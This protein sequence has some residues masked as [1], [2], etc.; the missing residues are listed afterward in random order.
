ME[1][2]L[3]TG[4]SG[5]LGRNILPLLKSKYYLDTLGISNKE[6]YNINITKEIPKLDKRYKYVLHALGKAHII[7]KNKEEIKEYFDVNVK[8]TKNICNALEKFGPPQTFI[9]I[10]SVSVYG[11]EEGSLITEDHPLKGKSPYAESKILAE[12]YLIKW[13]KLN[14]VK[15]IILRPSLIAGK[16][17]PGNLGAMVNAIRRGYFFTIGGGNTKKS[18]AMAEDIARLIPL[19]ENKEG[20]Y[21]LCDNYHPS[22]KELSNII[23]KQLGKKEPP[24]IPYWL[25][26][27]TAKIGDLLGEKSIFNTKRLEKLI[28]SLTFSNEKLK[29]E[30]NFQP[31]D[32]LSNFNIK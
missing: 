5:F 4:S 12:E 19:C 30:F 15:L 3:F 10:S 17:P 29:K 1:T 27:S 32:V 26:K 24:D 6:T 18:I 20:I 13:C 21:N 16:K 7:P 28:T 9:F 23:A 11:C 22:V 31:L 8:G 2:M 25:A 14:S